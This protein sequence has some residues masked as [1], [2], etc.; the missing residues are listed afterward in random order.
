[1]TNGEWFDEIYKKTEEPMR[2][3]FLINIYK[4]FTD[5]HRFIFE[6]YYGTVQ[7]RYEQW[8]NT[9]RKESK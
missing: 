3:F 1:M 5:E 6:K 4:D 7:E 8:R 9:Q 2:T